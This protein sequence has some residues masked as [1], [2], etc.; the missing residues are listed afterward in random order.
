[1][2]GTYDSGKPWADY[3]EPFTLYRTKAGSDLDMTFTETINLER[4]ISA[5]R[6]VIHV[7]PKQ[8]DGAP[9][10]IKLGFYVRLPQSSAPAGLAATWFLVYQSSWMATEELHKFSD[11]IA[12]TYKLKVTSD[13]G[14]GEFEIYTSV[15]HHS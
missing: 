4:S 11:L 7:I 1:M 15:N 8:V 3:M 2:P 10:R 6:N 14:V 5:A 13:G 12:G 9:D